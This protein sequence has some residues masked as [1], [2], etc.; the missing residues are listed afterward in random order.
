MKNTLFKLAAQGTAVEA[1]DGELAGPTAIVYTE[2]ILLLRRRRSVDFAKGDQG[3]YRVKAGW[4][5]GR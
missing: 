3:A 4:W 2:V 5:M 1:V